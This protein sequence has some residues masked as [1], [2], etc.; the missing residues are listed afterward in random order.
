MVYQNCGAPK[1]VRFLRKAVLTRRI[2]FTAL[3]FIGTF[4]ICHIIGSGCF[5]I[6]ENNVLQA[7]PWYAQVVVSVSS[8]AGFTFLFFAIILPFIRWKNQNESKLVEPIQQ[9]KS[10]TL[11]PEY[12]FIDSEQ[13]QQERI[14]TPETIMQEVDLMDG[15]QFEYWCADLLQKLGYEN[16]TVTR[17]SGDQ[18]VD[19][20]AQKDG[21][22]FAVQCKCYHSD[23]GNTPVQEINAGKII[24]HCHI[25]S[26]MTNRKFTT[27]GV[28]AAQATGILL[29]DRDWILCR[30]YELYGKDS[31]KI[32]S[33][34]RQSG[35]SLFNAAFELVLDAGCASVA[36]VQNGLNIGYARA[37]RIIDE[38][39]AKGFIGP[40]QGSKP[41]YLII[42]REDWEAIK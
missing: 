16:V 14:V 21:I 9:N 18:G 27:G 33:G 12:V 17:G 32:G 5:P 35:D 4:L 2:V 39:E 13:S 34:P 22:H 23:L 1:T 38:M 40:F 20:L 37:A 15:H 41:R 31:K 28:A 25:G 11:Q 42:T 7:P 19:V 8:L 29:W 36:I 30:L 10:I 3:V 24:Y 26:V 6:D